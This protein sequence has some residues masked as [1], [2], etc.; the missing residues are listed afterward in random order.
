VVILIFLPLI[1]WLKLVIMFGIIGLWVT[2]ILG[3][4]ALMC[5]IF[6]ISSVIS[7]LCCLKFLTL[8]VLFIGV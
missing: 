5:L 8:F 6:P 3:S 7:L 1:L 2:S 4:G